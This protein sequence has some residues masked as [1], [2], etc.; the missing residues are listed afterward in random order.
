MLG[1]TPVLDVLSQKVMPISS[2][3]QAADL[4][5]AG[6]TATRLESVA[7]ILAIGIR[8]CR[9]AASDSADDPPVSENLSN[10]LPERLESVRPSRLS[11]SHH[12]SETTGLETNRDH[13]DQEVDDAR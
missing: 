2:S 6:H 1:R 3:F 13:T 4:P 12:V 5:S 10:S 11:V 9:K 8:R 7:A